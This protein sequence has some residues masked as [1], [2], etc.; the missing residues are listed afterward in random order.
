MFDLSP[1]EITEGS[2]ARALVTLAA[3]L[4]VQNLVLVVQQAVDLFWLGR[5]SST[6]V[7]AVGLALPILALLFALTITAPFVG[8]QVLVSQRIGGED[9]PAARRT[10][11]TGLGLALVLGVGGGAVLWASARPLT[12]LLTLAQGGAG[13]EVTRLAT[14][15]LGVLALGLPFAA[16]SDAVEGAFIGWGDSRAPLYISIATVA[17]NLGLDPVLIF[18]WGPAPALGVQGA[19]FATVAGYGAGLTLALGLALAGRNG[20]MYSRAAARFDRDELRELLDV[21]APVAGQGAVRQVVRVLIVAIA[22][23][24]GGAAGLAAYTVGAR[25]ASIAFVPAIGLQQATQSVVGQNLGA[26]LPERAR[27][28]TYLGVAIAAVG[29]GVIGAIQWFVPTAIATTFAPELTDR[30]LAFSVDYLRILAY[31]Y[32]AI[33]VAYIFEAGFNGARRTRTSFVATVLQFWAVR[34]PIAAGAG[35]L[36]GVGID[37]VFWA[38]TISNISA[39]I[40]LAL[41]Y[42]HEMSSG[43]LQCATERATAAD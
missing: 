13:G 23:A 2:L 40:G 14:V 33:G 36:L 9:V 10:A 5:L 30:A 29:L 21:G 15:Y 22:F 25:I 24:A 32:P 18:G 39:A 8:T 6:A 3:P 16:A 42:R 34:L 7:A 19:A 37:A 12:D 28:A 35:V 11:A 41:Y 26:E 43:M 1:E 27:R 38:V 17:V 4:L 31:G 20:G